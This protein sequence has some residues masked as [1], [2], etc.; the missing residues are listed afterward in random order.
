MGRRGS[1]LFPA[2]LT[3]SRNPPC[4]RSAAAASFFDG[5]PLG[6]RVKV[7]ERRSG[8]RSGGK[9]ERELWHRNIERRASSERRAH[10]FYTRKRTFFRV[11][12]YYK[13]GHKKDGDKVGWKRDGRHGDEAVH[14]NHGRHDRGHGRVSHTLLSASRSVLTLRSDALPDDIESRVNPP[15]PLVFFPNF[16][17]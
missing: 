7:D 6:A 4:G 8:L 14:R 1:Y 17:R 3:F 12:L 15:T 2:H 11:G 16:F 10:L 13:R 5:K 9:R